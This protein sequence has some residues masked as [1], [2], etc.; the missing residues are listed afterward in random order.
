MPRYLHSSGEICNYLSTLNYS[1]AGCVPTQAAYCKYFACMQICI[2]WAIQ[3]GTSVIPKA[4][5][6]DH[7]IGNL[8]VL[9]W[10]LKPEDYEVILAP[11]H[12]HLRTMYILLMGYKVKLQSHQEGLGSSGCLCYV[13]AMMC[14]A[15][16]CDQA[17]S[18]NVCE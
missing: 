18:R 8:D 16:R 13:Q 3:H 7:I 9:D 14:L 5:S 17:S 6:K 12:A 4:T 11:A 2:R 10:E 15:S 1:G